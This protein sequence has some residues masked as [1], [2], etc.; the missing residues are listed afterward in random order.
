[1]KSRI[2]LIFV[3]FFLMWMGIILRGSYLQLVA[4]SRLEEL[5]KKQFETMLT[6]RSR[7]GAIFDRQGSELAATVLAYSLFAD[8]KIIKHPKRAARRLGK[9][10]DL[11]W[12]EIYKK[13]KNRRR[14]FVPLRR[15]L[16]K[17]QRTLIS[18]W[19]VRGL[20]FIEEPRRI[21]PNKSLLASTLGFVGNEG[22]G[23]EGLEHHYNNYLQGKIVRV[24]LPRDARGRPLLDDGNFYDQ[25]SDGSDV[26]LTIDNQLQY[27]L[28]RELKVTQEKYQAKSAVGVILDVRTSGVLAIGQ[29]PG[30]DLN[31]A[32]KFP[33]ELRRNRSVT[34]A[35]EPG[36]TM[37][38]FVM[39]SALNYKIAQP[40]TYIDCEG[41]RIKVGRRT[42]R[43][44]DSRHKFGKLTASE[45]LA[46]SSNVG[47]AK[48]AFKVGE[49]R[50]HQT[51][52]EFG[53]GSRTQVDLPGEN[54]GI[55]HSP[56]WNQH[57]L[58]NISFG[59]G[60]STTPLQIAAAYGAIAN[61]GIWR[62]PY[63]VKRIV[64]EDTKK[65][66]VLP[67]RK[68]RRVLSQDHAAILTLM[69]TN[70]TSSLGTGHN[71]RVKGFPVAGKTGTAQKVNLVSGGYE[72]GAYISSF[73]GF[74]PA[75]DPRFVI[76][77]AIDSPQGNY[78]GAQVAAPVFARLASFAV[79]KTGLSPVLLSE[80]DIISKKTEDFDVE[81]KKKVL[82]EIEQSLSLGKDGVT[83]NFVGMTLREVVRRLRGTDIKINFRGTGVVAS[84]KPAAGEPLKPGQRLYLQLR[85]AEVKVK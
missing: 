44:A 41:G 62:Q 23:L 20:G 77:I 46:Y 72:K 66:V 80:Q 6:I 22:H 82:L 76:Y 68:Q 65:E 11:S 61:G 7:R 15:H 19:K 64:F 45:I 18:K 28:E 34:D 71:A 13:I 52:R 70:A 32:R 63:L 5:K 31:E 39:A 27:L 35:F 16:N 81:K 53:F 67:E 25:V 3:L 9:Y 42:I 12:R 30:F 51:L 40:N 14:R 4:D 55:L 38:T 59:H 37:K 85:S 74:I 50:L 60:V 1:M 49:K 57:L 24:H 56:P 75:N 17:T 26:Y 73:A 78:Y 47:I 43:E 8:P 69:L 21:Y 2:I 84:S 79:R 33:Q 29:S 10:L 83:P 58:A 48:L 36:S 54:Q